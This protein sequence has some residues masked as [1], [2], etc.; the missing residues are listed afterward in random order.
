MNEY[1]IFVMTMVLTTVS[2]VLGAGTQST[3]PSAL[4]ARR[5]LTN[6][7][8][9]I[10][11]NIH[12]IL[13]HEVTTKLIETINKPNLVSP[14][15]KRNI[16]LALGV[17]NAPSSIKKGGRIKRLYS[18]LGSVQKVRDFYKKCIRKKLASPI[19]MTTILTATMP[20]TP[21]KN[22]L[23]EFLEKQDKK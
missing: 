1:R 10:S 20:P 12:V 19:E 16:L 4:L 23:L 8:L 2:I 21:E 14:N 6:P 7:A 3:G 17:K 5:K 18:R 11:N 9:P 15:S 22:K 13:P